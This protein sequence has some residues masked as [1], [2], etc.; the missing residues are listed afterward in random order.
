[1][2][3]RTA[4][5]FIRSAAAEIPAAAVL[6]IGPGAGFLTEALG[7]LGL[8]LTAVDADRLFCEAL[9][10][11]YASDPMV[12]IIHSDI[13]RWDPAGALPERTLAV[14]NIPYNITSPI[15]EWLMERRS[16]WA[17]V[18][19]TVQREFAERLVAPAGT[20]ECGPISVWM[21]LH[22][23]IRVLKVLGRG[24]F[25]PPPKVDSAVIQID[26][27]DRPMYASGTGGTLERLMRSA[28][29]AR[30]KQIV[31]AVR[32]EAGT[33]ESAERAFAASGV[34]ADRRPETLTL[35]DWIALAAALCGAKTDAS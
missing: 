25:S 32:T 26:F 34:G 35:Q 17:G 29:Q 31:H 30:R 18:V 10:A 3:D 27:L 7:T 4:L 23:R 5:E 9:S 28:F 8:P 14:G 12:R 1:M 16:L 33:R 2:I 15:L 21:Q 6:E 24:S 19:L 22:A 13:L 20:R 11:R